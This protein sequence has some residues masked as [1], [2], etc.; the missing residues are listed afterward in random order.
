M[1]RKNK[2]YLEV[3]KHT[4]IDNRDE[5]VFGVTASEVASYLSLDRGNV[6]KDLNSLVKEGMLVKLPGRPVK[7]VDKKKY[8][9]VNSKNIEE[10]WKLKDSNSPFKDVI[11]QEGSLKTAVNKAKAAILYP[12]KGLHTLING[13]TG[14]GKTTFAKK[15]YEYAIE[16]KVLAS[17]SKFVVFNC[18]EYAETP[19][20]LVS[21]IFGH[22]SAA[23]TGADKEKRGLVE[24]ADG[25][26]LFL[27][28]IHR[29]PPEG[30]EMLF[31]LMDEGKFRRLGETEAMRK[32]Q[33]LIIG[34]TTE[35]L[36]ES[37]LK[38]FLRRMPVV[39]NLPALKERPLIERLQFIEQFFFNEH[40][41]IGV[42]MK[43]HKDV[44]LTLLSYKC[45][46]N[47]GQLR[48]DIQIM[49]A[50][51]FLD[52]N[53]Q[54]KDIMDINN[55]YMQLN[56][57]QF[58]FYTLE[59]DNNLLNFINRSDDSYILYLRDNNHIIDKDDNKFRSN[60]DAI[61]K[62]FYI[63]NKFLSENDN[64]ILEADDI[65]VYLNNL[66]IS[67]GA[68]IAGFNKEAVL[69]YVD[70]KVYDAVEEV[71]SFVEMT[72]GRQLSDK[73]KVGFMMHVNSIYNGIEKNINIK[74][75]NL[76]KIM[77]L[78][79][80]EMKVAKLIVKIL[81]DALGLKISNNEIGFITMFLCTD[82]ENE[83]FKNVGVVIVTHGES[84]AR[85][86]ADTTNK[87]LNVNHCKSIDMNLEES[88]EDVY[89][90]TLKTV[91]EINEG[92]GVLLLFDMGSLC[93][94]ADRISKDTNIKVI[95][96]GMV[97]TLM[98]IEATR[99]AMT[100]SANIE[101][102]ASE[103]IKIGPELFGTYH[104]IDTNKQYDKNVIVVTCMS[105]IG[106][107]V[108]IGDIV[109][110]IT[111]ITE[112][113]NV[114]FK[115]LNCHGKDR[116]GN[117]L[118]KDD[119]QALIAVVGTVDLKFPNIPFISIDELIMGDGGSKIN[120]IIRGIRVNSNHKKD[121]IESIDRTIL[122]DTLK[123]LLLFIDANKIADLVLDS[124]SYI[125][126]NLRVSITNDI[127]VKYAIHVS[128]MIE[129]ILLSEI[130]PYNNLSAYIS[131][132]RDVFNCIKESLGEIERLFRINI[133]NTELAYI[134]EIVL[135]K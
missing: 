76:L 47:I 117:S 65:N 103:L 128:C 101:K 97:T 52:Y 91:Q 72:T 22:S 4:R 130:L 131:E 28:E 31:T 11:G 94:F 84:T 81:E 38:T 134:V 83:R 78:H 12:P 32:A 15:M 61:S 95:S 109:K 29:L 99:K 34:A 68:S 108:K 115:Y 19:Q 104:K 62:N 8:V 37:L 41:N 2:I 116:N 33:V 45:G 87:I 102:I 125:A 107:A 48:A 59:N 135:K 120:N 40:E 92:K 118:S 17:N 126:K 67:Y 9:E 69:K 20:L 55:S 27:D 73:T 106:A 39:I 63:Y 79:P 113:D 14:T 127:T 122:I 80:K 123:K 64:T 26:I 119:K 42:P 46:G 110:E 133:P 77:E 132:R 100:K 54:N 129:R 36:E 10:D 30:Q 112:E 56:M 53:D 74:E 35:C 71:L 85:S 75:K 13:P 5:V 24:E 49:C 43:V 70:A 89:K 44:I 90:R 6:S 7:F 111:K 51:A 60:F 96:V 3:E 124:L 66:S 121:E 98:A 86:I 57:Q 16:R 23:F 88:I 50:K 93:N 18:A 105:G 25:G 1:K 21:Q 58:Q 114:T 82:Y